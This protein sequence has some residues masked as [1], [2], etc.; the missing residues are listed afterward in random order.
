M[1]ITLCG[2]M[3][4]SA[5][6]IALKFELENIGIEVDVPGNV[7]N[8][9][10]GT[11]DVENK[12]EKLEHDVI[13]EHY[14]KILDSDAILVANYPKNE[15]NG[16][17]GGNSL[18]EMAFAHVNNKKI[19]LMFPAAESLSYNDEISALSH[20]VINMDYNIN[21]ETSI[22]NLKEILNGN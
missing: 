12:W 4:F 19:Y 13:R 8:Y 16:Y 10:N 3:K 7:E 15:V 6:M 21:N 1:K 11:I 18:I 22:N 2:S 14:R 9:A 17:I 5:E 20:K